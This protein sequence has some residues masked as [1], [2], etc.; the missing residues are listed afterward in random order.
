LKYG[1]AEAYSL[2]RSARAAL[3]AKVE[4]LMLR[5]GDLLGE[6]PMHFSP[7]SLVRAL[8]NEGTEGRR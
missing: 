6:A 7:E 2:W 3:C 5:Y 8:L 1:N 4:A